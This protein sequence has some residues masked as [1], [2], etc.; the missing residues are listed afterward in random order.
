MQKI[1]VG[2]TR[3]AVKLIRY[4]R[5]KEW[6]EEN[7]KMNQ[8]CGLPDHFVRGDWGLLRFKEGVG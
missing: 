6:D 7:I 5:S 4:R 2:V 8:V 1:P 3:V